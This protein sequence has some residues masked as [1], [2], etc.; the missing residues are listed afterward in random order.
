MAASNGAPDAAVQ[1]EAATRLQQR[2]Q[3][4]QQLLQ[5][6]I[7]ERMQ[8]PAPLHRSASE[9]LLFRGLFFLKIGLGFIVGVLLLL[10]LTHLD[11]TAGLV[12]DLISGVQHLGSLAPLA[13]LA[14]YVVLIALFMPAEF[15]GLGSGWALECCSTQHLAAGFI[16]SRIYGEGREP[17]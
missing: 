7:E 2:L 14:L 3:L 5:Q 12:K 15:M 4:Q 6:Q 11:A 10:A 1:E 17:R 9:A 13:Y 16:F 8:D